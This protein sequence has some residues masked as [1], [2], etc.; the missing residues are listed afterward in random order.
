VGSKEKKSAGAGKRNFDAIDA[1]EEDA[2]SDSEV[3]ATPTKQRWITTV[4]LLT[5]GAIPAARPPVHVHM[6]DPDNVRPPPLGA[7]YPWFGVPP[8][9]LILEC[10]HTPLCGSW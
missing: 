2:D 3:E 8:G 9:Q 4:S 1:E 6:V 7:P 5:P 10:L